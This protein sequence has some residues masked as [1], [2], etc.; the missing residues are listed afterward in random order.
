M[1]TEV[2]D[3]DEMADLQLAFFKSLVPYQNIPQD[4]AIFDSLYNYAVANDI[5]YVFTGANTATEFIRPPIER[6]YQNDIT[7]IRYIHKNLANVI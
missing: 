6:L 5:K 4:H 2:I 1:H 3:W 7:L